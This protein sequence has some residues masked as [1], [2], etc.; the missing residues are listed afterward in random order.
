MAIL[1]QGDA[2]SV[3]LALWLLTLIPSCVCFLVAA[4]FSTKGGKDCGSAQ[5]RGTGKYEK[6]FPHM[7]TTDDSTDEE[8]ELDD[9]LIMDMMEDEDL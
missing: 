5:S 8:K 1:A 4:A 3:G 6:M 2:Q 9:F 7:M